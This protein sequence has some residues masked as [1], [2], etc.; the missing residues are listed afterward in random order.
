[1]K[2]KIIFAW[3]FW[4]C[5]LSPALAGAERLVI[6]TGE[7]APYSS[8]EMKGGGFF[9]EIVSGVLARMGFEKKDVEIRFYPWKR[10]YKHV[11]QGKAWAA[12][13]YIRTPER[14]EEVLLSVPLVEDNTC[15]FYYGGDKKYIYSTPADLKAYEIGG[16]LGYYY[17][18]AFARDGLTV[19]YVSSEMLNL[20]KLV[21]GRIDLFPLEE[22]VGWHLIRTHFADK[23]ARFGVLEKPFSRVGLSLIVSKNYPNSEEL[24]NRFNAEFRQFA[25]QAAYRDICEKYG[26]KVSDAAH[27][28]I[29][30]GLPGK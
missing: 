26:V 8:K 24:L 6:A 20:R 18:A 29:D 23:A 3:V 16:V 7:Y 19:E 2:S 21:A 13:P 4:A 14:A 27:P 15:F 22:M 12:F 28:Q 11:R 17:T 10:A 1:M 25:T 5:W 30:E 9:T